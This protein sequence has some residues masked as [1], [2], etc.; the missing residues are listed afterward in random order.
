M[1]LLRGLHLEHCITKAR[2]P[3]SMIS[4]CEQLWA[5]VSN[6]MRHFGSLYCIALPQC[7]VRPLFCALMAVSWS[8]L[9]RPSRCRNLE[10]T[11]ISELHS[12][13]V[14]LTK[15]NATRANLH[16]SGTYHRIRTNTRS[17]KLRKEFIFEVEDNSKTGRS[18]RHKAAI[19]RTAGI[20]VIHVPRPMDMLASLAQ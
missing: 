19:P 20:R 13:T 7:L 12:E 17:L 18:I 8:H 11:P 3:V 6:A 9:L 5:A 1:S 2:F 16:L 4:S 10:A 14:R 15:N